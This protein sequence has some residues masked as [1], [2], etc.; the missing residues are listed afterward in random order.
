M[1][2]EYELRESKSVTDEAPQ[3]SEAEHIRI[4]LLDRALSYCTEDYHLVTTTYAAL[5]SKAQATFGVSGLF[6]A[7]TVALLNNITAPTE[8]FLWTIALVVLTY[9]LLVSAVVASLVALKV[10]E[11]ATPMDS[12]AMTTMTLDVIDLPDEELTAEVRANWYRDQ[13]R[14]WK[15]VIEEVESVNSSKARWLGSAQVMLIIAVICA[16]LATLGTHL[17]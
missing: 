11:V 12:A 6:I 13:L 3:G 9:G 2:W 5:D 1:Q 4:D 7:G 14:E 16:G 15:R 10:R 8:V 17:G